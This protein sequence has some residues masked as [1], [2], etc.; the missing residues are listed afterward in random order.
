M[1]NIIVAA[2]GNKHK[3]IEIEAITKLF[4]FKVITKAEAGVA[5]LDVEEN[6]ATFEENSKIKAEAIMLAT[7][8]PAIADDSGLEVD[9]LEGAPGIYSARF[10]GENATDQSNN[11]KLLKLMKDVPDDKRGAR[12]VS[13]ITLCYPDGRTLVARGHCPGAINRA[14]LGDN[15]FGYDPLFVPEG[16]DRTYAQI[17][18]EEKNAISHR[19]NALRELKKLLEG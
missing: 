11:E 13:V 8:M 5:D 12:F 19:A 17:T 3:I 7:G 14:P 16:F 2:T 4:G 6:G 10:S 9:A 18:S 1:N 15:G